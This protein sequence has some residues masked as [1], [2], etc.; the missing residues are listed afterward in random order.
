MVRVVIDFEGVSA[1]FILKVVENLFSKTSPT[2]RN[3]IELGGVHLRLYVNSHWSGFDRY[4]L[5]GQDWTVGFNLKEPEDTSDPECI[6]EAFSDSFELFS[7][8]LTGPDA[9]L[10]DMTVLTM[11]ASDWDGE[12]G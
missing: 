9:F 4:M 8:H 5:V 7:A 10:R 6:V 12:V 11:T 3:T 1:E 2:N